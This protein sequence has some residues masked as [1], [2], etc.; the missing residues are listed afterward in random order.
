MSSP[1]CT[2]APGLIS[3]NCGIVLESIWHDLPSTEICGP[4]VI[5]MAK[6]PE[7]CLVQTEPNQTKLKGEAVVAV[8]RLCKPTIDTILKEKR[9][10]VPLIAMNMFP[11][12]VVYLGPIDVPGST[13]T[14]NE[15]QMANSNLRIDT[16]TFGGTYV[17]IRDSPSDPIVVRVAE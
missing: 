1:G 13:I 5:L 9:P 8:L 4:V 11:I 7:K 6:S 15:M 12:I 16:T 10:F 2:T 14:E 17:S 3:H